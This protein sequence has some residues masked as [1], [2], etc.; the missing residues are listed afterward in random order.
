MWSSPAMIRDG[1]VV[2]GGSGKLSF[3]P[4]CRRRHVDENQKYGAY[5][6]AERI[7]DSRYLWRGPLMSRS[8]TM[9]MFLCC[10]YKIKMLAGT[11]VRF[12]LLP[13]LVEFRRSFFCPRLRP[14]FRAFRP[15]FGSF[16][17]RVLVSLF[18]LVPSNITD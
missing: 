17:I 5:S 6:D 2:C 7:S 16:C 9:V 1:E 13:V 15:D 18:G 4:V 14:R 10:A 8:E 3:R 11:V 12:I